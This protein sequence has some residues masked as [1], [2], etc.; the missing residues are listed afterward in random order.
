M[1]SM[2]FEAKTLVFEV[3][4]IEKKGMTVPKII[5][6]H[7]GSKEEILIGLLANLARVPISN[8]DSNSMTAK[9]W[10]RL[11]MVAEILAKAPIYL[12]RK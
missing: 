4:F 2:K 3:K 5:I 1:S 12:Q 10:K 11:I 9:Q 7:S 6:Q 8:F